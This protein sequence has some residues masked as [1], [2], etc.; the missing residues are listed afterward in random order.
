MY[1]K[2]HKKSIFYL[3][4]I[5]IL[6]ISVYAEEITPQK[7]YE[8][9]QYL[10]QII[11][12]KVKEKKEH[13]EKPLKWKIYKNQNPVNFENNLKENRKNTS[14]SFHN[15]KE[16]LKSSTFFLSRGEKI[17][18]YGLISDNFDFYLLK[19]GLSRAFNMDFSSELIRS[20]NN[21]SNPNKI[22][23]IFFE[24]GIRNLRG[25]GTLQIFS[26]DKG[27]FISTNLRLSYG[28]TTGD[29]RHGYIFSEIINK[30]SIS[31]WLSF[32]INPQFSYTNFGNI[33]S[34]SSSFNLKLNPK[35]EVIPEANINLHQAENNFSLTGRTYLSKNIII[36]TFVS[37][38]L[39]VIDMAK[40]FKSERTKFGVNIRFIF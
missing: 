19:I 2:L 39:G 30:Y 9:K 18:N 27:N 8:Q 32:N 16:V 24:K 21:S 10:S 1:K 15:N 3:L 17:F 29:L 20:K 22:K 11:W 13:H 5:S 28:E 4:N 34:I 23:N 12:E 25:G 6:L 31:D 40:Q 33:S 26:E 37:N 7:K 35:F 38:S 36:D 14:N